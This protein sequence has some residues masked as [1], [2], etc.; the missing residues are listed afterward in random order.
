MV[1]F[2][3]IDRKKDLVKLQMGEYV[4][5]G[6]VE[7]ALKTSS[8]IEN[9][10]VYGDPFKNFCVALVVP[11]QKQLQET[12]ERLGKGGWSM[13][14]M[15]ADPEIEAIFLK[16]VQLYGASCKLHRFEIPA[17]I[18]LCSEV[19]TPDM[20]LVTAAFKLRRKNIQEYYQSDITRMYA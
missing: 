13:E 18:K 17:V 1:F 5:L 12:A 10:C 3:I 9:I 19:W 8:F 14:R 7:S 16:E 20:G 11:A 2:K 4:S 6:K 15:C